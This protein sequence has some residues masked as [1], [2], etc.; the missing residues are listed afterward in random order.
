MPQRAFLLPLVALTTIV[1]PGCIVIP[2]GDLLKGPP[3]EEQVLA[4]GQ[5]FFSR[6]K[7]AIL[8]IDGIIS[9]SESMGLLGSQ[10]NTVAE[11]KA[12]LGRMRSDPDVVGMI[13]RISS[14]GGEVTACD[15]I[16]HEILEFKKATKI[17]VVAIIVDEGASGGYYVASAADTI[18]AHPTA[19][20]GSIGVI[21]QTFNVAGL[22]QKIGVES[23]AIKS[24]EKKDLLSPF[25]PH[26]EEEKQVLQNLI[27]DMY[28]RFVDVVAARSGGMGREEVLKVADGRVFSGGEALKLH[29]VDKVGYVGDAIEE[30]RA[31]AKIDR[32]PE[33]IR[34][35]RAARSG[36]NIY[37][38][39]GGAGA[40]PQ[41]SG[42]IT[43]HLDP[44]A[45][46]RARFL[47]LW[48]PGR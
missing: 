36:A 40:G 31:R 8:E 18:L 22:F 27:T 48:E 28:Q 24:S 23:L 3:L 34:Y 47:Y 21:I 14:P 29:L 42:G 38:A 41:D 12:R 4:R 1:L 9:G 32:R 43:L 20:V 17:P 6:D 7:I 10:A 2:V 45:F 39:F 13:L 30:V 26:T 33:I 19:I 11:V 37:S 35:S 16:H 44:Q 46:P 5:G 25:R 15:V